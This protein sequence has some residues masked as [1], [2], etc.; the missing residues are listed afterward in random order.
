MK[1]E[2]VFLMN[3]VLYIDS[4]K[5]LIKFIL[6]NKKCLESCKNLYSSPFNI[7]YQK[8]DIIKLMK[9]FEKINTL[10]CSTGLFVYESIKESKKLEYVLDRLKNIDFDCS[11][12]DPYDVNAV[13]FIH[14]YSNR[15]RYLIFKRGIGLVE[16]SP[17]P[18][19]EKMEMLIRFECG[20]EFLIKMTETPKFGKCFKK[21]IINLESLNKEYIQ[22]LLTYFLNVPFKVIIKVEYLNS[23]DLNIWKNELNRHHPKTEFILFANKTEDIGTQEFNQFLFII[24]KNNINIRYCNIVKND[25]D[26][27][28]KIYYPIEVTVW[29]SGL[30]ENDSI[31]HFERLKNIES[32]N[33]ISLNFKFTTILYFPKTLTSLMIDNCGAVT[34]LNNLQYLPLKNLDIK[35]SG[36]ISELLLPSSLKNIRLERLFYLKSIQGLKQCDL[37]QFSIFSC[38]EIKELELPKVLSCIVFQCRELTKVDTQ[39]NTTMT[40]LSLKQCPK[41]KGIYLPK[42]LILMKTQWDNKINGCQTM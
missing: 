9:L 19:F 24:K 23:F 6:I 32:L 36:G 29:N 28:F 34:Q 26:R 2:R 27:V 38:G 42:S 3:V 16:Y 4:M 1:L 40:Y 21:L 25:I 37:T 20:N 18:E 15:I 7:D 39:K 12:F 31:A 33:L 5:T 11:V 10:H 13:S 41:L 35:Y 17:L 30:E 22:T 8:K 14:Y